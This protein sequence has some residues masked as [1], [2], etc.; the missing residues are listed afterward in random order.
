MKKNFFFG[1]MALTG[2]FT[3]CSQDDTCAPAADSNQVSMSIEM[4]A[5]FAKT[6]AVPSAPDGHQLRCILEVWNELE[7]TLKV[8]KEQLAMGTANMTFSFELTEQGKYTAVLWADYID[9][10][11]STTTPVMIG[12][13]S[14]INHYADKYYKTDNNNLPEAGLNFVEIIESAY[15]ANPEVRDAFTAV[16]PFTKGIEAK[17][18][19]TA[20]LVRPLTK[21]TI[22][23]KNAAMFN[24]CQTMTATYS[25][26]LYFSALREMTVYN[27]SVSKEFG[28]ITYNAAPAGG[29]ITI[30][31]N[32]CKILFTDYILTGEESTMGEFALTFV[33]ENGTLNARTIGANLP[34]KRNNWI[35]AAGNLIT[36]DDIDPKVSMSVDMNTTWEEQDRPDIPE[37]QIG[38]YY[39]KDGTSST[40]DKSTSANPVIGV[41]YEVNVDGTGHVVSL[42]EFSGA[43]TTEGN[44]A[45]TG[46]TS[47]TDGKDNTAK[48][49]A[50][51][52]ENSMDIA[53]YPIFNACKQLRDNTG[54]D[55][56]YIPA[57]YRVFFINNS[58]V[59]NAINGKISKKSGTPIVAPDGSNVPNYWNSRESNESNAWIQTTGRGDGM[60]IQKK[61]ENKVRFVLDF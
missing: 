31:Q 27:N 17:N 35:R 55:G 6:R 16:V 45:V 2:L 47:M 59:A 54:N 19:L 24:R 29:D 48:V 8:R 52:N 5:D 43:W 58:A 10:T 28:T 3:A 37:R 34:L 51:I 20:T 41:V 44:Y 40:E 9:A 1:L 12:G 15:T 36:S 22:A 39:Y 23:E 4:P 38:D 53:N 26:P 61:G 30:S 50:Y 33:P 32:D 25:V 13:L 18:D 46:A 7:M 21:V 49:F 42:E 60:A 57:D 56:W 14:G 11:T